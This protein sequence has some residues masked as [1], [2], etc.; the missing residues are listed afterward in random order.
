MSTHN[1]HDD[2]LEQI[3]RW[4]KTGRGTILPPTREHAEDEH[5]FGEW[6]APDPAPR[7]KKSGKGMLIER[8][9]G[10]RDVALEKWREDDALA[11]LAALR[12]GIR[13]EVKVTYRERK[14]GTV[15]R[16][17]DAPKYGG[18]RTSM[19]SGRKQPLGPSTPIFPD[20]SFVPSP[21]Y[22]A[23][24]FDAAFGHRLPAALATLRLKRPT[25]EQ[26]ALKDEVVALA[27]RFPHTRGSREPLA[28]FL[29]VREQTISRWRKQ[30]DETLDA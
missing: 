24:V 29:G 18:R 28:D 22:V 19:T 2:M 16:E 7:R 30:H 26:K 12:S 4:K 21:R 9:S 5:D 15:M 17:G 3:Q 27:V 25:R 10:G 6:G 13:V 8:G 23:A 1:P 11:A 20:P 14:D